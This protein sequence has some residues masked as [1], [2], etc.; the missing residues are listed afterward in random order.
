MTDHLNHF[1]KIA[2]EQSSKRDPFL[3]GVEMVQWHVNQSD[4]TYCRQSD[5][6][7]SLYLSGG[8]TSFRKDK[9][10]LYGGPGKICLM[11]EQ[12]ESK[13]AINS[14]IDFLHLYIPDEQLKTAASMTFSKDVRFIE[15]L[16]VVYQEDPILLAWVQKY[17]R[18]TRTD[19][20]ESEEIVNNI[21][22]H[23]LQHYTSKDL[24]LKQVKGGLSLYHMRR[25]NSAIKDQLDHKIT[26]E[27]LA[28]LI[29]LSPFH[30]ARM[31]KLS[32]GM[33]P[34]RYIT[35]L[36]VQKVKSL[37]QSERSLSD[38]S[39]A[40]GFAQ[41]SHM[42]IQFKKITGFTPAVYRSL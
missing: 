24:S 7:L 2:H 27:W 12:S 4:V 13:W 16:D 11:P 10:G 21:I 19:P 14:E 34:S 9:Q 23:L 18:S 1:A 35:A 32:F 38:I 8:T 17:V 22:V 41:Q 30:F 40:A 15:L 6:T 36:R 28:A 42:S 5:H 29:G 39:Y 3:K 20:V 26:I 37:L 25:V 31:F 33:T